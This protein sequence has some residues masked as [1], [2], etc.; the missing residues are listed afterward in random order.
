MGREGGGPNKNGGGWGGRGGPTKNP[1][2]N[3]WRGDYYLE[4]KSRLE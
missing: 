4:P 1:K 3:K 2:I